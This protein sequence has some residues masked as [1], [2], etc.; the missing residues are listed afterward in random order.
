MALNRLP[1]E[2]LEIIVTHVLPEGFESVAVTCKRIYAL[3]IPFIQH[4]NLL[5][6]RFNHFKYFKEFEPSSLTILTA[7]EL[8]R[9]IAIEPIV[10]RYIRYAKLNFDSP[11]SYAPPPG[12][13]DLV[14]DADSRER[15]VNLFKNS[16]HLEG[17]GLGWKEYL[18]KIEEDSNP[19]SQHAAAFLLTLLPNVEWLSLPNQWRSNDLTEKL[20]YAIVLKAKTSS[21]LH[22]GSSLAQLTRFTQRF[23]S[24]P[25]PRSDWDIAQPFLA[26]PRLQYFRGFNCI[27]IDDHD[28]SIIHM[29]RQYR[30]GETLEAISLSFSCLDEVG[31]AQLLKDTKR[32]KTFEYFHKKQRGV[33][34]QC[35]DICNFVAAIERQVGSHLV[36]LFISLSEP[37]DPIAPGAV[38][39]RGFPCLRKLGFPLELVMCNIATA[40]CRIATPNGPLVRGPS[41]QEMGCDAL[42][43]GDIVPSSVFILSLTSH[44]KDN[45]DKA[46]DVM[47]QDFGARKASALPALEEVYLVRPDDAEDAYKFQ[48]TRLLIETQKAGVELHLK[49][50]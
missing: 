39:M 20:V 36:E 35:W 38:S 7:T 12:F 23:P 42:F 25:Q 13:V 45:H 3:C 43:I 47:F 50:S 32:L 48:C 28:K 31:I 37:C 14:A 24:G 34:L 19:Y 6:S 22:D 29:N 4:H 10:A 27:A 46:L 17:A 15:L 33:R 11:R 16:P 41:D 2:I 1:I 18:D 8:I 9:R 49:L 30:F 21:S 44:G 26:L 5:R 40:A